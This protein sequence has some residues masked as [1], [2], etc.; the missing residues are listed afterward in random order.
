MK[1]M[2]GLPLRQKVTV[3]VMLTCAS[4]LVIACGAFVAYDYWSLRGMAVQDLD[5]LAAVLASESAA[6]IVFQDVDMA[7]EILSGVRA[8]PS[9]T[10]AAVYTT[11]GRLFARYGVAPVPAAL[12]PRSNG[13]EVR[14]GGI[15]A[16]RTIVFRGT[17]TGTLYLLSDL[18]S[19][20]RSMRLQFATVCSILAATLLLALLLTS[21]LQRLVTRPLVRLAATA[22]RVS[23]E[24]DYSVRVRCEALPEHD[25]IGAVVQAFNGMLEQIEHRDEALRAHQLDLERQVLHRTAELRGAKDAAV[26]AAEGLARLSLHNQTIL[27]AAGEGI[28]GLDP[29]GDVTFINPSGA[30]MLGYAVADLTGCNLHARIHAG[31]TPQVSVA[32]CAIC[33][34]AATPSVRSGRGTLIR[35]G[36]GQE[37]PVEYVSTTTFDPGG[38]PAGVVVTFRDV[39]ERLAIERMKDEFVSTVSHEL[40][41]PLTSIRGALGLLN[42]GLLD[43]KSPRGQRMLEI[44]VANTD[45]LGR[46]INEIL[47]LEKMASGKVE[48]NRRETD[49]AALLRNAAESMQ[50]MA[51]R[52]GVALEVTAGAAELLVDPDRVLQ[53]LLNLISN[54]IKFSEAGT[55]VRLCGAVEEGRYV[56]TVRDQGRGVPEEKLESIFDRFKQVDAS[57]SRDKGGTGL[58]LAICRSIAAAHGGRI[59]AE[60][61]DPAGM[62][63]TFAMPLPGRA[64][65]EEI[66]ARLQAGER[67]DVLIVED[68]ADLAGVLVAELEEIGIRTVHA[69]T[70]AA[71][72]SILAASVPSL[73]VLDLVLP[74]L[75][76][77]AIV[78]WVRANVA[79]WQIP[80][81]VYSAREITSAEQTRLTLGPTQFI[82]KSR[83]GLHEFEERVIGL[84][85][86]ARRPEVA[87]AA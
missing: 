14:G 68:D 21:R 23:R 31:A 39:T 30:R 49:A 35:G 83:I 48:L 20:D 29:A 36:D 67:I 54:A 7:R 72:L 76:G 62:L 86:G 71:A 53:M 52:A 64:P 34:A 55:T 80:L 87:G 75:D 22:R 44:A 46:L 85:P 5:T 77:F 84:L 82:T 19:F 60:R 59:W 41:T 32:G 73:I 2:R 10:A 9:I 15:E 78:E 27:D 40:R 28:F 17:P 79:G 33:G 6:S 81:L 61:A 51:E 50:P 63:F 45:R 43:L 69:P 74:D 1:G 16:F 13:A 65:A 57:D 3:V 56:M 70:G 4:A 42:A 12:R 8:R 11:D 18:R 47:D 24:R 58:G 37:I 26:R 66:A 38:R 25:E